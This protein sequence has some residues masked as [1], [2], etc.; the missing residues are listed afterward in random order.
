MTIHPSVA[1]IRRRCNVRR[2]KRTIGRKPRWEANYEWF[3]EVAVCTRSARYFRTVIQVRPKI[4]T[5]LSVGHEKINKRRRR[6]SWLSKSRIRNEDRSS[7][8]SWL[9]SPV[10]NPWWSSLVDPPFTQFLS[11]CFLSDSYPRLYLWDTFHR[12]FRHVR[13]PAFPTPGSRVFERP[14]LR[15]AISSFAFYWLGPISG[16]S[17][18]S[19]SI[20]FVICM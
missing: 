20:F 16:S 14:L 13:G 12:S 15:S 1:C 8:S 6:K 7:G 4:P 2:V 18:S 5:L 17:S 3:G 10:V 9:A 11:R 19:R